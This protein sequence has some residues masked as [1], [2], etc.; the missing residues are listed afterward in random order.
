MTYRDQSYDLAVHYE[1][2]GVDLPE[3]VKGLFDEDLDRLATILRRGPS[4]HLHVDVVHHARTGDYHIKTSLRIAKSKPFFTGD[5]DVLPSPAFKRC[6]HK[7]I[8]KVEAHRRRMEHIHPTAAD[9]GPHVLAAIEPEW[10]AITA[11]VEEGDYAAFRR[12]LSVYEDGLAQRVGREI[13]RFPTAAMALG[14]ELLLSEVV[15][16]V[17]L[18]A[19]EEFAAGAPKGVALSIWLEGLIAPSIRALLEH[20]ETEKENIAFARTLISE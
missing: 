17:F 2:N 12:A 11:A 9:R 6:V 15:E 10:P 1:T 4:A 18:N 3:R 5:R 16:E 7:L 20:P 14:D 8:R 13:E 19:F